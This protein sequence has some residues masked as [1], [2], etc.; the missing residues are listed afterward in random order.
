MTIFGHILGVLQIRMIAKEISLKI[1][2]FDTLDLY[3]TFHHR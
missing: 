3:A 2:N 1:S